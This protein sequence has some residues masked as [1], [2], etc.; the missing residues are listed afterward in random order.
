MRLQLLRMSSRPR[1]LTVR[2]YY[3]AKVDDVFAC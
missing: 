1:T 3:A 2:D